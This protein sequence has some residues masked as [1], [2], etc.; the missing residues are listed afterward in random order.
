MESCFTEGQTYIGCN[1]GGA[2]NPSVISDQT[3]DSYVVTAAS[4]STNVFSVTHKSDGT[5]DRTCAANT[6]GAGCPTTLS[7]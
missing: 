1:S 7:W 4:K 3:A 5:Y 6:A 2:G